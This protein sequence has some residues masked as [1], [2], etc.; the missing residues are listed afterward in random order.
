[1]TNEDTVPLRYWREEI[2]K[3]SQAALA[4]K[5]GVSPI[6]VRRWEADQTKAWSRKPSLT[7]LAVLERVSKG[8][9]NALSFDPE[10]I[11]GFDIGSNS[12]TNL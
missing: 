12:V 3:A 1:M 10:F 4:E 7:L 9:V 6:T 5:M 11:R 8:R 2:V